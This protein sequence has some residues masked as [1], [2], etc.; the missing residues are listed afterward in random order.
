MSLGEREEMERE[1]RERDAKCVVGADR[2]KDRS[3]PLAQEGRGSASVSLSVSQ[4]SCIGGACCFFWQ[5]VQDQLSAFSP[6]PSLFGSPSLSFVPSRHTFPSNPVSLD[7]AQLPP[8]WRTQNLIGAL[9]LFVFFLQSDSI[10]GKVRRFRLAGVQR[11]GAEERVHSGR[12]PPG[13]SSG[14]P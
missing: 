8:R 7:P 14:A 3:L 10:P 1:S 9:I 4:E 11:R 13:A 6:W 2:E 5:P 12:A